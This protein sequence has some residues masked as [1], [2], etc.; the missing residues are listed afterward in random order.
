MLSSIKSGKFNIAV[1]DLKSKKIKFLSNAGKDESP[2]IAPN[3]MMV[4]YGVKEGEQNILGAVTIDGKFRMRV[5][6]GHGNVK[7]PSWSPF[8]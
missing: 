7:E 2:T 1:M 4:L 3:G 5:P 6:L 8:L